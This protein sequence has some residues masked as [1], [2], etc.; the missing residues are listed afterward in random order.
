MNKEQ[1]E[2]T[3][4]RICKELN[5]IL[6]DLQDGDEINWIAN[7]KWNGKVGIDGPDWKPTN[8]YDITITIKDNNLC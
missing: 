1:Q 7:K 8:N 3:I 6:K 5:S 2:L 4:D